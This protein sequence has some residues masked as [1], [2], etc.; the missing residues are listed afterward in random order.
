MTEQDRPVVADELYVNEATLEALRNEIEA[1]VK[2][3]LQ[4]TVLI[5]LLVA[6][7]IVI[8][9]GG[10]WY[11]PQEVNTLMRDDPQVNQR[12]RAQIADYLGDKEGGE[13][14]IREQVVE[15]IRSEE[16]VRKT[17]EDAANLAVDRIVE[18]INVD[19]LVEGQIKLALDEKTLDEA[20]AKFL[21]DGQGKEDLKRAVATYFSSPD[22]MKR[23]TDTTSD[24]LK[25]PEFRKIL[26]S[27]LKNV[28]SP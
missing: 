8:L 23:L 12:F 22:G 2:R 7:V 28:L 10:L 11:I 3:S 1:D 4:R 13:R 5:P 9:L 14:V 20:L 24:Q 18:R 21:Q 27:E 6:G 17:V 25:S 26:F 15:V 16:S 19:E